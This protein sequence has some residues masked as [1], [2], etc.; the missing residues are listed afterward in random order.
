MAATN[1]AARGEP[2]PVVMSQPGRVGQP[3]TGPGETLPADSCPRAKAWIWTSNGAWAAGWT[4]GSPRFRDG[5]AGCLEVGGAAR[6]AMPPRAARP[7]A[8]RIPGASRLGLVRGGR[9]GGPAGRVRGGMRRWLPGGVRGGPAGG[10]GGGR[11][12]LAGL[13]AARAGYRRAVGG[14]LGRA[15]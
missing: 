9:G 13:R 6:R 7:G 1:A 10:V 11:G 5:A 12:R 4:C 3:G 8:R 14:D 15:A 2:N